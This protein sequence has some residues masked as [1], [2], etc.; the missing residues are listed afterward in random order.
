MKA[1]FEVKVFND[2]AGNTEEA[3]INIKNAMHEEDSQELHVIDI[4]IV[5]GSK[6][7]MT[8]KLS[9]DGARAFA[10]SVATAV[11]LMPKD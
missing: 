2:Y 5:D 3:G 9:K 11:S 8:V 6:D 7:T 1:H 10:N 4:T